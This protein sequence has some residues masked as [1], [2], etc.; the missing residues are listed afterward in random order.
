MINSSALLKIQLGVRL[1]GNKNFTWGGFWLEK[2]VTWDGL[3]HVAGISGHWL[4][5]ALVVRLTGPGL[6]VGA[7]R[8]LPHDPEACESR[9]P[10]QEK[11]AALTVVTSTFYRSSDARTWGFCEQTH[12][13][14]RCFAVHTTK[15]REG[16]NPIRASLC[17]CWE[18]VF[19][20]PASLT[21]TACGLLSC[22]MFLFVSQKAP[23]P[24]G[25]DT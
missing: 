1:Q 6:R 5:Q 24:R 23:G 13:V 7:C 17:S 10:G 19:F 14:A 25:S 22:S 4:H 21:G 20:G 16:S 12:A 9:E 8:I 2:V 3:L 15:L 11:K 18:F